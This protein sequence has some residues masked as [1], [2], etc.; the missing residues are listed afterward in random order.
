MS[1]QDLLES[2]AQEVVKYARDDVITYFDDFFKGKTRSLTGKILLQKYQEAEDK[3]QFLREYM[4]PHAVDSAIEVFL[5]IFDQQPRFKISIQN[6]QGEYVDALDL[7][8]GC[9]AEYVGADGW[10]ERYSRH[11]L[12]L[13]KI[14]HEETAKSIKR[15]LNRDDGV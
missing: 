4:I 9:E 10:V 6:P 3:E 2:F 8:D 13:L 11:R 14:E 7:T 12:G 5:Q 15:I 1:Q